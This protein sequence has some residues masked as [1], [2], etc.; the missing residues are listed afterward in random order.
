MD[1]FDLSAT[2]LVLTDVADERA[3]QHAKWGEQNWPDGTGGAAEATFAT[4]A[5]EICDLS[6][7]LGKCT[8]S[9]ILREEFHEVMA[10][11]DPA[12]LRTELIQLAAVAVQWAEAID[13]RIKSSQEQV[14]NPK[15][16]P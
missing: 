11:S 13:R 5:K 16:N 15:E 8:F 3:K 9:N 1:E 14:S 2:F 4:A 10:E 12:K 6:V 7:R